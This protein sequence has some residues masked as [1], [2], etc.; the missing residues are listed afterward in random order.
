MNQCLEILIEEHENIRAFLGVVRRMC[1]AVLDGAPVDAAAFRDVIA[2]VREYADKHH[3]GKEEQLLFTAM[4]DELGPV[5]VNLIRH[6]MLVEHD[7]GRLHIQ[8][9]EAAL[10][11]YEAPQSTPDKL[12]ILAEAAGYAGL[13]LRHLE[14]ENQ[15]L[16]PFAQR[17]LPPAVL[18][19]MDAQAARF[20]QDGR[21]TREKHLRTLARL[22]EKYPA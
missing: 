19:A 20:E 7:L 3:H 8:N 12:D 21:E 17:S 16:F 9:L 22:L 4:M 6:G 14:K 10:D 13:L 11:R 18:E 2:F 1:C 5:A 15:V